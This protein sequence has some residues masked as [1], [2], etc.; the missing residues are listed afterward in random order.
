MKVK[1]GFIHFG[2]A[3]GV[4]RVEVSVSNTQHGPVVEKAIFVRTAR[5]I[6]DGYVY[7]KSE[8]LK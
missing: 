1:E 6:M 4:N 7:V 8:I 5:R 3:R 2:H